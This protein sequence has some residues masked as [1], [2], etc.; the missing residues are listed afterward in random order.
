MTDRP[1]RGKR[2]VIRNC[3]ELLLGFVLR[4]FVSLILSDGTRGFRDAI[5]KYERLDLGKT[6]EVG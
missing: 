1:W 3:D 2:V 5:K 4:A 6:N